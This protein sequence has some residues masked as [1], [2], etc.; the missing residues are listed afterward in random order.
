[1][2]EKPF[3]IENLFEGSLR[4]LRAEAEF[5]SKLTSHNP[6]LGRMNESHLVNLLRWYLPPKFGIGTGFIAS[7]GTAPQQ[8]PQCDIIIYDALNNAPL[9]KSDAWSIFPIEM[10]YG[11]IE[12]KTTLNRQE[13][14]DA[15]QKCSKIRSMATAPDGGGNKLYIRL[16]P[17]PPGQPTAYLPLRSAL[18]P[19]FFVFG[20]SGWAK[21]EN[22]AVAFSEVSAQSA[23]AHVH[24]VCNLHEDGSLY[25]KH[26]AFRDGA[27][28]FS[29][30]QD[31][32]FRRFL[33]NLPRT[34]ASMLPPELNGM[35]F[36]LVDMGHYALGVEWGSSPSE[37][38]G[39]KV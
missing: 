7:G 35:G 23:G 14:A 17:S 4:R 22:L 5:F 33:M 37:N 15:F 28:R 16:I 19:R 39:A 38:G 2:P 29:P 21:P 12:V 24:G 36:D 31:D 34:L 32:G 8:S 30:V 27:N 13:L 1:M 3:S 20:Y 18:P 9:Y 11:V 26:L 6:E 10:V 25:V